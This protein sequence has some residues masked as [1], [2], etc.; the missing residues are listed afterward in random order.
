MLMLPLVEIPM[1][2]EHYAPHFRSIFSESEYE[3]FKKYIS[4]LI[5][6]E[7]KSIESIN[8]L[9]VLDVKNQSS[10]NRFLTES[11]YKIDEIHQARLDLLCSNETTKMKSTKRN[12]GV[13]SLD[14]TLLIHYGRKFDDIAK[15]FDHVSDTYVWA[16]NL[17]N[18]H[19]SD[20][21][22]GLSTFI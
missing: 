1:V 5:V 9:F 3:H 11:E 20:E 8:R 21:Q 19:Y 16:H 18:L 10:L 7:N 14:D 6:S 15:L 12:G 13:I 22:P 17:V 2:V 4:G